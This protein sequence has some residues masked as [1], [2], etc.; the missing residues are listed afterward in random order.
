MSGKMEG[1]R[2]N[3]STRVEAID[4]GAGA[5]SPLVVTV[6]SIGSSGRECPRGLGGPRRWDWASQVL[7]SVNSD[8]IVAGVGSC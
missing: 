4:A 5:I 7:S 8:C 3:S 2:K 6:N 1:R